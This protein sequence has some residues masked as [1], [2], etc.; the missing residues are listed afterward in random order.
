MIPLLLFKV[1]RQIT[2][3]IMNGNFSVEQTIRGLLAKQSV[4]SK[5]LV[6]QAENEVTDEDRL[7]L[8]EQDIIDE[9]FLEELDVE[10]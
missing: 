8:E 5:K 4:D 3:Q 6:A 2:A 9:R 10:F 7:S 1:P